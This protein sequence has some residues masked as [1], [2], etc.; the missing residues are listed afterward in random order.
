[1]WQQGLLSQLPASSLWLR[2]QMD[3]LQN[4]SR[5]YKFHQQIDRYT[6]Q[7]SAQLEYNQDTVHQ[8]IQELLGTKKQGLERWVTSAQ[9]EIGAV[10]GCLLH[11][12]QKTLRKIDQLRSS[13]IFLHLQPQAH[14]F[15]QTMFSCFS[16]K[17]HDPQNLQNTTQNTTKNNTTTKVW[18]SINNSGNSSPCFSWIYHN[19]FSNKIPRC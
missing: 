6:K 13:A 12:H 15:L 16:L 18:F 3:Q 1:M 19:F 9:A 4:A 7:T 5:I 14:L 2:R 17:S 10:G 11:K 8:S